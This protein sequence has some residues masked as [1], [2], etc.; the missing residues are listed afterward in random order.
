MEELQ[1]RLAKEFGLAPARTEN[2]GWD[3]MTITEWAPSVDIIGDEKERQAKADLP[4]VKRE[5]VNPN[6]I[7]SQ[8]PGLARSDYPGTACAKIHEP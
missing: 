7:P 4:E 3:L 1:S 6:G 5:E 2:G 8:S